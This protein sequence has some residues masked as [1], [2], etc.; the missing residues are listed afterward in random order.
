MGSHQ[1]FDVMSE[2]QPLGSAGLTS[3]RRGLGEEEGLCRIVKF[4]MGK[5]DIRRK[6]FICRCEQIFL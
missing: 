4:H 2:V 5:Y 6:R 1:S 3:E